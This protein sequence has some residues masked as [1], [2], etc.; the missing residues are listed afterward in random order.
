MAA[1]NSSV[2]RILKL[3]ELLRQE[4]DENHPIMSALAEVVYSEMRKKK[5]INRG[6][7]FN[8]LERS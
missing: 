2:I 5:K 1:E 6:G 3:Y 4:T 7:R 8:E